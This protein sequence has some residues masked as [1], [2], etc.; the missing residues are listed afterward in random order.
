MTDDPIVICSFK[1]R[2][3]RRDL[4]DQIAREHPNEFPTRSAV[5]LKA[6]NF[7]VESLKLGAQQRKTQV[8]EPQNKGKTV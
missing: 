8:D 6:F 7:L 5:Y 1:D 2:R 3:S 4:A